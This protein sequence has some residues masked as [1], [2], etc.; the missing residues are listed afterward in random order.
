MVNIGGPFP[1]LWSIIGGTV[2]VASS[3][4]SRVEPTCDDK[5]KETAEAPARKPSS[6]SASSL[7][8]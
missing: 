2:F 4:C 5:T 7:F 1:I 3:P 6:P 8:C